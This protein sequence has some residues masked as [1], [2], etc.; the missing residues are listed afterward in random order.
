MASAEEINTS[1]NAAVTEKTA[2][3]AEFTG[4]HLEA[5]FVK[6]A[7]YHKD[8]ILRA[9]AGGDKLPA[10]PRGD[11]AETIAAS[12]KIYRKASDLLYREQPIEVPELAG[13][14]SQELVVAL[15]DNLAWKGIEHSIT[16]SH[17]DE[18]EKALIQLKDNPRTADADQVFSLKEAKGVLKTLAIEDK[19]FYR[20]FFDSGLAAKLEIDSPVMIRKFLKLTSLT[21]VDYGAVERGISL[22]I[23]ARRYTAGFLAKNDQ[24]SEAIVNYGNPR[25]DAEGGDIVVIK[26]KKILHIDIKKAP[27]QYLGEDEIEQGY[28][29]YADREKQIYKAVVWAESREAVADDSFRLTDP[30]L[31]NSLEQALGKIS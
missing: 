20:D 15:A 7:R 2:A 1:S 4:R 13:D 25:E 28:R 26:G 18:V 19:H 11:L 8:R 30:R 24:G 22:E 9:F 17:L 10:L 6:G 31:Q 12:E 27:P 23:A 5:Y 16:K 14:I 3:A 29:F 21:D